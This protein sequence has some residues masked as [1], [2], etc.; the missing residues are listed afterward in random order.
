M[1]DLEVIKKYYGFTT[2]E[3]K[4]YINAVSTKTISRIRENF[5][6]NAKKSFYED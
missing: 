2:D 6:N 5:E 4:I 3:A 1:S